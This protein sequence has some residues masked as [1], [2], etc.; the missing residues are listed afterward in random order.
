[1]LGV[2]H[3]TA[4]ISSRIPST[5]ALCRAQTLIR[6]CRQLR[7]AVDAFPVN[8]I[9]RYCLCSRMSKVLSSLLLLNDR[10][11]AASHNQVGAA[12]P[13]DN[14]LRMLADVRRMAHMLICKSV[15]RFAMQ[16]KAT[17]IP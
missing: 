5:V 11:K 12:D 14:Y 15:S 6:R 3:R 8:V 13:A 4:L 7:H 10:S 1:M 2:L 17:T 16:K 9:Q